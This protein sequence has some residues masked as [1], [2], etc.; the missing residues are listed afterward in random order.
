[1]LLRWIRASFIE[2]TTNLESRE[3]GRK[4]IILH[5]VSYWI[6]KW[7]T[8]DNSSPY[9]GLWQGKAYFCNTTNMELHFYVPSRYFWC[10]IPPI[11]TNFYRRTWLFGNLRSRESR[12]MRRSGRGDS[13]SHSEEILPSKRSGIDLDLISRRIFNNQLTEEKTRQ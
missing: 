3:Y 4:L 10:W 7:A 12:V 5:L 9:I 2:Q 11:K 6:T 8:Y 1:M 13:R